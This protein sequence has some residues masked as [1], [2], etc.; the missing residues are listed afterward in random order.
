MFLVR[1]RFFR[2]VIQ[3]LIVIL[4]LEGL[5]VS[6]VTD[7]KDKK[8]IPAITNE[9]IEKNRD[10]DST[11]SSI[12]V[13]FSQ[14]HDQQTF[15]L[16]LSIKK[17]LINSNGKDVQSQAKKLEAVIGDLDDNKQLRAISKLISLTKDIHKQRDFFVGLTDEIEKYIN[18]ADIVSGKVYKQFCPMAL[19]GKGGYWLSDSKEIRNPYFGDEMLTCGSIEKVFK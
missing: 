15:D 6:C 2:K 19:E 17:A 5:N 16:Y 7:K 1:Y 18:K 8:N 14:I 3:F 11:D 13:V 9:K 10:Y 12:K 4:L